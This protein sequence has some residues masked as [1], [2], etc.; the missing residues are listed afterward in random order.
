V[1][2]NRKRKRHQQHRKP[3]VIG[4]YATYRKASHDLRAIMRR[5]RSYDRFLKKHWRPAFEVVEGV[6]IYVGYDTFMANPDYA[7]TI[8]GQ[9]AIECQN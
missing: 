5:L 6:E 3:K 8:T 1:Q 7:C 9:G 2:N 4:V